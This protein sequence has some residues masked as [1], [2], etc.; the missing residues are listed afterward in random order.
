[1][2][3][4]ALSTPRISIVTP[5]LNR[6]EFIDEAIESVVAQKYPALEHIVVDGGSTDGTLEKLSRYPHL[7]VFTGPDEGLYDALNKGLRAATGEIIGHLNS[8]DAYAPRAFA[9][10][11][12][13]FANPEIDA[14][15]GGADVLEGKKLISGRLVQRFAS[16]EEIDLSFANLTIG[17]PI[18]NARFFRRRVYERVGYADLRYRI[19]SD[20]DFLLRVALTRPKAVLLDAIIYFYRMHPGSLTIRHDDVYDNRARSEYV[21]IAE[22]FL[23]NPKVPA[24]A[25]RCCRFWH[26]RETAAATLDAIRWRRWKEAGQCVARGLREDPAWPIFLCRQLTG[27]IAGKVRGD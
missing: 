5:C 27:R 14:V 9:R 25:R 15:Y 10:I 3:A 24:E 26:S 11:A 20:R 18:T 12:E 2:A 6:V 1:M 23:A 8:D 16:P 7:R 21:A 13:A 19:A 17:A 22:R 4:S